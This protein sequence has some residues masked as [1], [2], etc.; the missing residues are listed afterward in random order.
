MGKRRRAW[1]LPVLMAIAHARSADSQVPF[2]AANAPSY[3]TYCLTAATGLL[4]SAGCNAGT[5]G[6]LQEAITEALT[7]PMDV[8]PQVLQE[9]E[10]VCQADCV[11]E[12]LTIVRHPCQCSRQRHHT[13]FISRP[14]SR[15]ARSNGV[16]PTAR[17]AQYDVEPLSVPVPHIRRPEARRRCLSECPNAATEDDLSLSFRERHTSATSLRRGATSRGVRWSWSRI[18]CVRHAPTRPCWLPVE[19]IWQSC[20]LTKAARAPTLWAPAASAAP[21]DGAVHVPAELQRVVLLHGGGSGDVELRWDSAAD[22][23]RHTPLPHQAHAAASPREHSNLP[24]S[25][26]PQARSSTSRKSF[27][28]PPPSTSPPST[29]TPSARRSPRR[30]LGAAGRRSPTSS[31]RCSR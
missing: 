10:N 19:T 8:N 12:L 30:R 11:G 21:D 14:A 3:L 27:R 18:S 26:P 31:R 5:Y 13:T 23:G 1:A 6:L 22:L 17:D 16:L 2:A 20:W 15:C 28:T 25:A 9:L 29:S 4:P 7:N 24:P